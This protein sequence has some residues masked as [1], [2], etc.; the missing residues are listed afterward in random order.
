MPY[1]CVKCT[2]GHKYGDGEYQRTKELEE[3]EAT[4]DMEKIQ[5]IKK[6]VACVN[7]GKEGHPANSMQCEVLQT[8]I[9]KRKHVTEA[10]SFKHQAYNTFTNN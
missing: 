7:C 8:F 1:R 6:E 4:K 5:T 2:T 3:A 9:S 10:I